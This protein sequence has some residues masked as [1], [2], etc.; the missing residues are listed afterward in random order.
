MMWIRGFAFLAMFILF[1]ASAVGAAWLQYRVTD[2]Q[3]VGVFEVQAD[4]RPSVGTAL[5][6]LPGVAAGSVAWPI[7]VGCSRGRPEWTLLSLGGRLPLRLNPGLTFFR[8]HVVT[9]GA[10]VDAVV[11]D[12]VRRAYGSMTQLSPE[13]FVTLQDMTLRSCPITDV[14]ASCDAMRGT[15]QR[16]NVKLPS[17]AQT[18]TMLEFI[19]QILDE[20][21]ALKQSK[22]Y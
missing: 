21:A 12:L 14:S 3:V 10:E 1:G 4:T 16:L 6:E 18:Q 20:G 19:E 11:A 5:I 9:N 15:A 2:L 17:R 22:R 7:P 13:V 8:C